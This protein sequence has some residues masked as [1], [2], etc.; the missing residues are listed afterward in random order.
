M[1]DEQRGT[2]KR[3]Y[4]AHR[5]GHSRFLSFKQIK[6]LFEKDILRY[7]SYNSYL[8][9]AEGYRGHDSSKIGI[10]ERDIPSFILKH[11]QMENIWPFSDNLQKYDLTTFFTVIEFIYDYVSKPVRRKGKIVSYEKGPAQQDYRERV[12]ELLALYCERYTD[13]D[14]VYHEKIYELSEEGE[15]RERVQNG[16]RKM[17]DEVPQTDDSEN[18]D[19]K[20]RYAVSRFLRYGS[21]LEEKKD[22][23]RTLGD[24]LEFL[25]KSK[26]KMPKPDD[27]ALFLIL[28]KFSIRHHEKSQLSDYSTLEWYEYFFYVFLSSINLLLELKRKGNRF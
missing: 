21:T 4:Y 23:I 13:I 11:L 27:S 26:I 7:I 10:W 8:L 5:R 19:D 3:E 6:V 1:S 2:P 22:A 16:F 14:R 17:I 25:K 20:I 24:V 12:N 18:I 9:E 28:N 15:I